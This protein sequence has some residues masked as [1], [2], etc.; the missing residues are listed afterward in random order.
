MKPIEEYVNKV[1]RNMK[2]NKNEIQDLKNEMKSHLIESVHELKIEGKSEKEAIKIAIDRFGKE[3]ELRSLINQVFQTQKTFGKRLL[4]IGLSIFLLSIIIFFITLIPTNQ[5]HEEQIAITN[6]ILEII[7]SN[8]QLTKANKEQIEDLIK[9][10]E[11]SIG[12]A[13]VKSYLNGNEVLYEYI[14]YENPLMSKFYS[15]YY[16][17][18][19]S[20]GV[21]IE[22]ENYSFLGVLILLVGGTSFVLFIIL[23]VIIN[24]YNKRQTKLLN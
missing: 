15:A 5:L 10:A 13:V 4:Y 22:S 23:W 19:G 9:N 20:I 3:N 12:S 2:G 11:F 16:I 21:F 7:P 24:T 6:E 18:R 17:G 14:T 1:Y 8:G